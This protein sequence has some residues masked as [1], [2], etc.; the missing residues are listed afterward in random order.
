MSFLKSFSGFQQSN[1]LLFLNSY[2]DLL[3]KNLGIYS[4]KQNFY[5]YFLYTNVKV[6]IIIGNNKTAT[7]RYLP[8]TF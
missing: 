7:S 2:C 4:I 8:I 6:T 5:M 3:F 1:P